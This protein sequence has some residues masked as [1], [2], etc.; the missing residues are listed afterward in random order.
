VNDRHC[1]R[2]AIRAGRKEDL[3]TYGVILDAIVAGGDAMADVRDWRWFVVMVLV[4]FKRR[5]V[6]GE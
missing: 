4:H 5:F 1:D 2:E 3:K 6:I